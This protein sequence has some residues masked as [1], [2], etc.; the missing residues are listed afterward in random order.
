MSD[1]KPMEDGRPSDPP[2]HFEVHCK[3]RTQ[4]GHQTLIFTYI[5]VWPRFI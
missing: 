1:G 5:I 2:E 3:V 4:C